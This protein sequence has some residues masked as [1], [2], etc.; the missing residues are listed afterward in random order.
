MS[1]NSSDSFQ[2]M[3]GR[4]PSLSF[5]LIVF[6]AALGLSAGFAPV[7]F[8]TISIFLKPLAAEFAW[9]RAQASGAAVFSMLGL[10]T[11]A[12]LVGR[13]ID[14]FGPARVICTSVLATT[15]LIA[16]LSQIKNSPVLFTALSFS[17][18]FVGAGTTP[19]G[20]LSILARW[21]EK[22]LGLALGFAGVGMGVGTI[23]MPIVANHLIAIQGWRQAYVSLA[24]ISGALG[25]L[26][27]FILFLRTDMGT[28]GGAPRR[29]EICTSPGVNVAEA[30]TSKHLW[31][32]LGVV[33]AVAVS[34]LGVSIHFVPM[35]TDRGV[36]AE[37]A[38]RAV[39]I[40]GAGVVVGRVACGYLLDRYHA[41][42]IAAGAFFFAAVGALMLSAGKEID[43]AWLAL[44]GLFVGFALGAE[45]DFLPFFVRK[46][47]GLRAFGSIYG[48]LFFAHG[49]GGVLGPVLFGLTFDHFQTYSVALRGAALVLCFA[50]ISVMFM[51]RYRH[52]E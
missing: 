3:H 16:L 30:F 43:F 44:S 50:A 42:A 6:G 34:S 36:E 45:G 2:A 48:I 21:F 31:L 32:L 25:M 49:V 7:Y 20:Y 14:R 17:I 29:P 11:G 22:R 24:V 40:S 52:F 10:A 19:P 33:T 1:V 4:P 13:L 27:C 35:L 28:R 5:V 37:M 41:P 9:G 18:G 47:F 46:Y 8:G 38:A 39:A 12:I 26:A 15:A 51:G 23:L